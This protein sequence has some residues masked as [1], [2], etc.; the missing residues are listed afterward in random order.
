MIVL[1]IYTFSSCLKSP[2]NISIVNTQ[3]SQYTISDRR[4]SSLLIF[5]TLCKAI[6]KSVYQNEAQEA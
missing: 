4:W 1:K 6:Y 2:Q 3:I 5:F